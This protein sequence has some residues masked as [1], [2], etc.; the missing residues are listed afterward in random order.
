MFKKAISALCIMCIILPSMCRKTYAVQETTVYEELELLQAL[1][2]YSL[3]ATDDETL[4]GNVGRGEFTAAVVRMV[5]P[6]QARTPA[7]GKNFSDIDEDNP[8]ANEILIAKNVGL[9]QG[10]TPGIFAPEEDMEFSHAVNL[11]KRVLGYEEA[12]DRIFLAQGILKGV[13]SPVG[14]L[15]TKSAIR[16]LHNALTADKMN[17]VNETTGRIE[18]GSTLLSENLQVTEAEGIVTKNRFTAL[19]APGGTSSDSIIEI[20]GVKYN[21]PTACTQMLGCNVEFYYRQPEGG[22]REILYIKEKDCNHTTAASRDILPYENRTYRIENRQTSKRKSYKVS[23]QA[24]IIYNNSAGVSTDKAVPA[25]GNAELIDNNGDSVI[26]VIVVRDYKTYFVT[27][28]YGSDYRVYTKNE[29][30]TFDSDTIVYDGDTVVGIG[31]IKLQSVLLVSESCNTTGE[32][33]RMLYTGGGSITGR[34]EECDG[35]DIVISGESYELNDAVIELPRIGGEGNFYTDS[36]GHI[37]YY[38]AGVNTSERYGYLYMAKND[39]FD[40]I[41]R[42]LNEQSQKERLV[43]AE[44]AT[45]DGTRMENEDICRTLDGTVGLI[46]YKQNEAGEV[47]YIDTESPGGNLKKIPYTGAATVFMYRARSKAFAEYRKAN[48]YVNGTLKYFTDNNTKVFYIGESY[49]DEKNFRAGTAA[50]FTDNAEYV[51]QAYDLGDNGICGAV[52]INLAAS[53]AGYIYRYNYLL[54]ISKSVKYVDEDGEPYY[55][56]NGVYNGQETEY[57]VYEE[58]FPD[59]SGIKSGDIIQFTANDAKEITAINYVYTLSG[60][61]PRGFG[62]SD[63]FITESDG[64]RGSAGDTALVVVGKTVNRYD[65]IVEVE[66]TRD[67]NPDYGMFNITAGI[68]IVYEDGRYAV[69]SEKNVPAKTDANQS[70]LFHVRSGATFEVVLINKEV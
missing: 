65:G 31:Q 2:I 25:Y 55:R 19:Y 22:D 52:V 1:G 61:A 23:A 14:S 12:G 29:V 13:G 44:K 33:V 4:S 35:E 9:V 10:L 58:D 70:V 40:S 59:A 17:Y 24:A 11:L 38:A 21:T 48:G 45:L 37:A 51:V 7:A 60:T 53:N 49:K 30:L 43:V 6:E 69:I 36:L 63:I 57:K 66:F 54:Y 27:G 47:V 18:R 28:V 39:E 20:D 56:V 15:D 62:K 34:L 16:L 68:F 26:D 3:A 32:K 46:R 42:L 41:I 67:A 64:L 50:D 8:Y 5:Y